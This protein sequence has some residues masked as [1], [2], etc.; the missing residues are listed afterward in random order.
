[1]PLSLSINIPSV[2]IFG[3]IHLLPPLSYFVFPLSASLLTGLITTCYCSKSYHN[4]PSSFLLNHPSVSPSPIPFLPLYLSSC[5][6]S[7]LP[8]VLILPVSVIRF[9]PSSSFPLFP[10]YHSLASHPPSFYPPR[11]PFLLTSFPLFSS[12][13]SQPQDL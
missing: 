7:F 11:F 2:L 3:M 12:F 6:L 9:L 13:P 1:M 10:S 5:F 8:S 4:Y